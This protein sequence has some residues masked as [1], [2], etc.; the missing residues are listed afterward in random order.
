MVR[1]MMLGLRSAGADVFEYNTDENSGALD[2]EGRPYDRGTFGPVWLRWEVLGVSIE[3]FRPDLIVCNAGGL[4]FRP[5]RAETLRRSTRLLGIALSDPD[6]FLPAT[7]R[8]AANFDL[9][10][11]NAS[12]CLEGYRARGANVMELP[13][14]TNEEVFHAVPERPELK[15]EVLVIGQAHKDRIEPVRRLFEHFAVHLY[16][17]GWEPHGLPSRGT[18]LGDDLLSALNSAR[19]AV[20]FSRTPAGHP[21]AKV[22]VLDFIAGGAL[23]AA[24]RIPALGRYL[25]FDREIIG[26]DGADDLIEKIRYCLAHPEEAQ[27]IREAGRRRVLTDH[28]WRKVWPRIMEQLPVTQASRC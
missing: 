21:I 2:C 8:I 3:Q 6:V 19:I 15:C 24:E 22:A 20:V 5:D 1:Q 9:F 7:S 4:S 14:A 26:F 13:L 25:E 23:L 27:K 28:T 12:S 11:T 16:G 10:L 17:E 18:L